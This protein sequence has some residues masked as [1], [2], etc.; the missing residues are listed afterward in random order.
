MSISTQQ[1]LFSCQRKC[2]FPVNT[3]VLLFLGGAI[4]YFILTQC[5]LAKHVE[6]QWDFQ[7]HVGVLLPD[8]KPLQHKYVTSP[9]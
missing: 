3:N 8:F 6:G 2:N 1:T 9:K 5:P 4:Q 7:A